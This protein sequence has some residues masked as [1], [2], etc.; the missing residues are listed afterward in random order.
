MKSLKQFVCRIIDGEDKIRGTGF[1]IHPDGYV[2]TC[3]HVVHACKGNVGVGIFGESKPTVSVIVIE[4][5]DYDIAV[6]H[7]TGASRCSH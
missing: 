1:F 4:D 2:A 5:E 7:L 6:L 3:Y